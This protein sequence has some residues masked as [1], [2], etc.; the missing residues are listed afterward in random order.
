MKLL[1]L[2]TETTDLDPGRRLVQLAYKNATTGVVVNE[3]FKPPVPISVGS[4][5]VHHIT[6]EIVADRPVFAESPHFAALV[7]ELDGAVVVA[8]NA[9]FDVGVLKNEGVT[10]ARWIDT[11]RVARHLVTSEQYS[12]QYLRYFLKLPAVGVAHDALGDITILEALFH[13]LSGAVTDGEVVDKL[14]ELTAT[15][16]LLTSINFGKYRG[17]TFAEVASADRDY[18]RWLQGSELQ[19]PAAEQNE[20]FVFTLGLYCK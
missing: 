17:K 6:N 14:L 9:P 1:F 7:R 11:C 4:M 15:P 13:H 16:V 3:F 10:V 19:K 8:H 5:A 2:D 20:E 18:L 12:L